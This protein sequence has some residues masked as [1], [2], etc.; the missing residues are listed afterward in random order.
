MK[1][2]RQ[3]VFADRVFNGAA[4]WAIANQQKVRVGMRSQH[5]ARGEHQLSVVFFFPKRC[6]DSNQFRILGQV[7]FAAQPASLGSIWLKSLGVDSVRN[8]EHF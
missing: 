4:H 1:M 7:Q 8:H 2:C 3:P 6:H 5:V